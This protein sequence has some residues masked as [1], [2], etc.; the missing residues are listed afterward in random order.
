MF[1]KIVS[2]LPF[3]PGLV[4]QL[5]FYAKRL[6]QEE[7][8]RRLGLIFAALALVVQSLV[9]F[10]PPEPA[11]AA[12]PGDFVYGGLGTGSNRS[13]NNFLGPYDR[14]HNGLKD[15]MNYL[16]ITRAEIEQSQYGNWMTGTTYSWGITPRF[17]YAQGERSVNVGSRT[18][19][20][21]P[22]K[23]ANGDD[24]IWGWIGHSAKAGWFAI[25]QD[26]G[27]PVTTNVPPP[28]APPQPPKPSPV[29]ACTNLSLSKLT[30]TGVRA[31]ATAS[32]AGGGTVTGYHFTV[33]DS[34]GKVVSQRTVQTSELSA[35][36]THDIQTPGAYTA[37]VTVKTSQGDKTGPQC[38][39]PI[40]IERPEM[41][42]INP[43][44]PINHPDCQPCP[45]DQT[46]WVKDEKCAAQIVKSK[47]AANRDRGQ[48]SSKQQLRAGAKDTIQYTITAKND[49]KAPAKI[50]LADS[51]ADS[52]EYASLVD[53]AGGTFDE[54]S[55][56]LSWGE[57]ALAPG[58]T[59]SRTFTVK[60]HDTIPAAPKGTSEAAS[61]DCRMTNTFGN[62]TDITVDCPAPKVVE[63]VVKELPH[64]G[65]GENMIFAGIFMAVVTYF[66]ARSR[67]LKKEVRLIRR[68]LNSGA[69]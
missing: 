50:E 17:S 66:Y 64:T 53:K 12:N 43:K 35:T 29:T 60:L 31:T 21:R 47:L 49:G 33:K 13:L 22:M 19:Y 27:N 44:L 24:R 68:N 63:T 32:A 8:T 51:L 65:P 59:V 40:T 9:L 7:F 57:V 62:S 15:T 69:I 16:G 14:N 38:S 46:I 28:P 30:R 41:C 25:M 52:L 4:G 58:T 42:P 55:K 5:G 3:N 1:R 67:Q 39:K 34:S 23:L 45:G 2:N 54:K 6:R 37:Q 26:C 11:N 61:F 20:A 10:R 18:V 56:T 36:V 48:D